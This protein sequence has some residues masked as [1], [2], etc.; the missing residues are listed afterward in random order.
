[1]PSQI[2]SRLN[3]A[4]AKS[5][6]LTGFTQNVSR[7]VATV[8]L[9]SASPTAGRSVRNA[10]NASTPTRPIPAGS[11]TMPGIDGLTALTM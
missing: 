6:C 10:A 5:R 3:Q 8:Y 4:Q 9:G 11:S 7:K 2:H 1:M